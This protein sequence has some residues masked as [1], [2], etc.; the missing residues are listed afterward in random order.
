MNARERILA[1]LHR[2]PVD[3]LPV[4]LWHTPEVGAA[5]RQYCG[6]GDDLSMYRALNLDKIVWVFMDYKTDTGDRAGAR[7]RRNDSSDFAEHN[8]G[9]CSNS[10]G[11]REEQPPGCRELR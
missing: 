9:D 10:C 2:E 5:L 11:E 7:E 6:V 4:D 8:R 1:V 3:R